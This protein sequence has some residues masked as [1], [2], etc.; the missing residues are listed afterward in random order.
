V[1]QLRN[2]AGGQVGS[3]AVVKAGPVLDDGRGYR[4]L[5]NT[6]RQPFA[7]AFKLYKLYTRAAS[8]AGYQKS[9]SPFSGG[10]PMPRSPGG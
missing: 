5:E 4:L 1:I 10:R 7:R 9:A 3:S 6:C 8:Y 2:F